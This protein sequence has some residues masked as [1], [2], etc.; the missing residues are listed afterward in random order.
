[1]VT[2]LQSCFGG[3]PVDIVLIAHVPKEP[4]LTLRHKHSNAQRMNRRVSKSL[5]I[6]PAAPVQ[7][8]EVFF[9]RFTP[10]EVQ[11]P[12][13][14]IGEEL[15]VIIVATV[16]GV[17]KPVEVS[18]RMNKFRVCVDEGA[19]AGPERGEGA[20][21]VKDVHVEAIFHIIV[22]HE[23]KDIVVNVTKEVDLLIF[24]SDKQR[25][26]KGEIFTSGSTRQY[27][28]NSLRRGCL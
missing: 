26:L 27:Q 3:R 11:I 28:S 9:V 21:I 19:G 6:E 4:D 18:I 12:N 24:V 17:Q 2:S 14:E 15:A 13:L 22:A 20:C 25:I 16:V 5:I 8:L 10:E 23:A 7:P 1:M